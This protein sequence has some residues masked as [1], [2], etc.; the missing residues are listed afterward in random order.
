MR[1]CVAVPA[2]ANPIKARVSCASTL[3][4]G[5][6]RRSV[7]QLTMRTLAA[8]PS[9]LVTDG[10]ILGAT[11]ATAKTDSAPLLAAACFLAA[12]GL[13]LVQCLRGERKRPR[14]CASRA[15]PQLRDGLMRFRAAGLGKSSREPT[16]AS[17][18]K[19]CDLPSKNLD[20]P[21]FKGSCVMSADISK[22]SGSE[23][24]EVLVASS[25]SSDEEEEPADSLDMDV[26]GDS[27]S[28]GAP[29][30]SSC[31]AHAEARPLWNKKYASMI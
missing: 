21:R 4:S 10:G 14:L 7:S 12:A 17:E 1:R 29:M 6:V 30:S 16:A 11:A 9:G 28:D 25:S 23:P 3:S 27:E 19:D 15:P 8:T 13:G 22:R 24:E 26:D 5:S 2:T 18:A 20:R 31:S